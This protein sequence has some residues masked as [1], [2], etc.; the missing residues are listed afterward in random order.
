MFFKKKNVQV[1]ENNIPKHVGIIMDGNG[2]WAKRKNM[3]VSFGH[4]Q[5]VKRI[6][7]VVRV[8]VRLKIEYVTIYAFS[9]ENWKRSQEEVNHLMKLIEEFYIKK[10]KKLCENGVRVKIVGSPE[11]IPPHISELFKKI[12][13]ESKHN[14]TTQLNIAFNYGSRT[15]LVD[16]VNK[17]IKLNPNAEL[18]ATDISQNLYDGSSSD[19]DLLIRTS[20]EQR[21]SNFLLWQCAYSEFLFTDCL[22]PD[23]TENEFEKCIAEYQNRNRRFGGR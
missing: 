7:D 12:E 14:T 18:T 10:F 6:E 23:F 20:G 22:W 17:A 9:T 5:G 21:L 19:V 2:R 4:T 11:N 16:A 15:E 3:P 13:E 8:A 1:D